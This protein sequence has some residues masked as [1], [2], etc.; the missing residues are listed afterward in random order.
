MNQH[1]RKFLLDT[2]EKQFRDELAQLKNKKPVEPSLNN[3]LTA[4]ILDGSFV[5]R[6][7]A[8][9]RDSIS[10]R[11]RDLGKGEA[12]LTSYGGL[13]GRP[14]DGAE[15]VISLPAELLFQLPPGYSKAKA[16]Y[17]AKMEKWNSEIKA[18]ENSIAAMRIKVQIGS[19]DAL[20]ALVNQA[21]Q[22][23][24][25]SLTVSSKLLGS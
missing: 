12:L 10:T 1:Q 17:D 3:Y 9:I 23:C 7:Q 18:L 5:M 25:M 15:S 14:R 19:D 6:S 21:D 24:S 20:M 16:E 4:A 22:L 2:I 8:E 11:V 13:Y